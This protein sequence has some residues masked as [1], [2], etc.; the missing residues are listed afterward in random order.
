[1]GQ[2]GPCGRAGTGAGAPPFPALSACQ[3]VWS[4]ALCGNSTEVSRP[5]AGGSAQFHPSGL[6]L[7]GKWDSR[8][9][10]QCQPCIWESTTLLGGG[11][12]GTGDGSWGFPCGAGPS[13]SGTNRA[14]WPAIYRSASPEGTDDK[15]PMPGGMAKSQTPKTP[16]LTRA[17]RHIKWRMVTDGHWGPGLPACMSASAVCESL[18][19][20]VWGKSRA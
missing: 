8:C 14:H 11:Y 3:L 12:R 7:S 20:C 17:M 13:F 1:M 2:Q 15:G 4:I 18:E 16:T 5:I 6:T 9:S 10:G 19:L